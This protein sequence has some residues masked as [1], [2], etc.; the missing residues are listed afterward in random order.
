[1]A[2]DL[3]ASSKRLTPVTDEEATKV[4]EARIAA[5][6]HRYTRTFRAEIDQKAIEDLTEYDSAPERLSKG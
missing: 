3:K 6:A 2:V 4:M 1:M 5:H